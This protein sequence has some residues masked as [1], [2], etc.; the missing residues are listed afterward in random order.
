MDENLIEST[1]IVNKAYNQVVNK[2]VVNGLNGNKNNL[3][4]FSDE[5][6][7]IHLAIS[8]K[9]LKKIEAAAFYNDYENIDDYVRDVIF[10]EIELD[11]ERHLKGKEA[12][13][14]NKFKR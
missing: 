12:R 10:R 3:S 7:V 14:T 4:N 9:G 5:E 1:G 13:E 6:P 8:E 2:E 11:K